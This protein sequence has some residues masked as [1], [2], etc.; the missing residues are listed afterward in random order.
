MGSNGDLYEQTGMALK[1]Q[2]CDL[3]CRTC[4]RLWLAITQYCSSCRKYSRQGNRQN[5][6]RL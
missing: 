1:W 5:L 6:S 2:S 4:D 3:L